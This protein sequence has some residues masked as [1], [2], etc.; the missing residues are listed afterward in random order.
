MLPAYKAAFEQTPPTV[1]RRGLLPFTLGHAFLLDAGENSFAV[2]SE[3]P[4][5]LEDLFPAVT[6]CTM[7]FREGIRFLLGTAEDAGWGA[8]CAGLDM[9]AEATAFRAYVRASLTIPKRK[10]TGPGSKCRAPWQLQLAAGL[11][12]GG[13]LTTAAFNAAM[14]TP[15]S[16]AFIMLAARQAFQG[17]ESLIGED[18]SNILEFVKSQPGFKP[19]KAA[20]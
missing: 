7:G 8:S 9:V 20:T 19:V 17:D 1:L 6:L 11:C 4:P 15:L 14:D 18:E 16:E 13:P 2:D 12:D 3:K 10:Q 5:V